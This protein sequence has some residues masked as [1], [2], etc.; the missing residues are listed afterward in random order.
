MTFSYFEELGIINYNFPLNTVCTMR[1]GGNAKYAFFPKNNDQ[2]KNVISFL[3]KEY[4]RY[5]IL[6]NG[7][8]TVFRDEGYDGAVVLTLDMKSLYDIVDGEKCDF[9]LNFDKD[10]RTIYVSSGYSLTSLAS[11]LLR[12]GYSG[13]E[14]AYGIPASVG[15][16][17][18]M[19]AGAYGGEMKNVIDSVE[20]LTSEGEIKYLKNSP[21][22]DYFNYRHSYFTDH[23]DCIITGVFLKL[24]HADGFDPMDQAEKNMRSRKEK[25]PLEYPSCGSAFKRPQGYYAGA[26]IEQAGLK[27]FSIGGA[28]VSEK[29]AGFIVNKGGAT[30][31]D[32]MALIDYVKNKVYETSGVVLEP[33]I[34]V[35]EEV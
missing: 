28:C 7:S 8:N 29:H 24:N 16:A 1:T 31:S 19:N 4:I 33:E 25:Q 27:G 12:A 22:L 34:R 2:L 18:F 15:G 14:F 11:K 10:I 5:K 32:V 9:D 23:P 6:G 20:Y 13:L 35:V 30:T 21:E 26:L 17:V 3:K